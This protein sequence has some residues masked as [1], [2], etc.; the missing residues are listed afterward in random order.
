MPRGS[1]KPKKICKRCESDW[2]VSGEKYCKDCRKVVLNE[3][4]AA[5]Y[6]CDTNVVKPTINEHKDRPQVNLKTLGGAVE[7]GSDGDE[8]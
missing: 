8:W 7:S 2:A 5:G 6:L 4:D 1:A 3:L